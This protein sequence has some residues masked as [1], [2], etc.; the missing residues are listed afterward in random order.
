MKQGQA[1]KRTKARQL[2]VL[3]FLSPGVS[4]EQTGRAVT[5]PN[6]LK[7][8][9]TEEENNNINSK[10]QRMMTFTAM[11]ESNRDVL[12]EIYNEERDKNNDSTETEPVTVCHD[13]STSNQQQRSI[14]YKLKHSNIC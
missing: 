6:A 4:D 8:D 7:L 12:A 13:L 10:F 14:H 3:A 1:P 11:P 2:K 5:T 9:P